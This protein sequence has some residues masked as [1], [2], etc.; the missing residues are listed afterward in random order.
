M[1]RLKILQDTFLKQSPEQA[2]TLPDDEK[3]FLTAGT[4]L[5]L[6]SESDAPNNHIKVAFKDTAFKGLNTWFAFA[7]HVDVIADTVKLT[8][9]TSLASQEEPF[10]AEVRLDVKHLDQLDNRF[11]PT[12]TCNVT[13]CAMILQFHGIKQRK[14]GASFE[15][16]LYLWIESQGLDRYNHTHLV[17]LLQEYGLENE[18][19]TTATWKEIKRHLASGNPVICPGDYT[20][21]GH[22]IVLSGYNSEGFIVQD[23]NGEIF[24]SPG[25][26]PFYEHNSAAEPH[27][28]ANLTYSYDLM[29]TLAGPNGRVWA[30]FPR[31]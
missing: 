24:W 2:S 26:D 22:I 8:V 31:K 15:D 12:T 7:D 29:N 19:V 20:P 28:G 3:Q 9:T 5:A 18:F 17:K 13:C 21:S 1:S 27:R 4:I 11:A 30:H 14:Q 6:H 23:P 25:N 10:P 16:E